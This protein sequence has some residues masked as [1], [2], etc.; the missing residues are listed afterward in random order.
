M[1]YSSVLRSQVRTR[2]GSQEQGNISL[3]IAEGFAPV[4]QTESKW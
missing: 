4:Q 3:R 2:H 1:I